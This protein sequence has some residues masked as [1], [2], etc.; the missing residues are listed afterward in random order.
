MP[1]CVGLLDKILCV[2]S[3]AL[4]HSAKRRDRGDTLRYRFLIIKPYEVISLRE[5]IKN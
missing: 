5:Y 2:I 4:V 1:D 3:I